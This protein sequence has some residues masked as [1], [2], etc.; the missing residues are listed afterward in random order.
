MNRHIKIFS[1]QTTQK[2]QKFMG[3]GVLQAVECLPPKCKALSSI[4]STTKEEKKEI[5]VV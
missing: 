1:K 2:N 3:F 4:P 5:Q